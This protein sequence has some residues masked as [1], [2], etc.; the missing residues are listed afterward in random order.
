MVD[1]LRISYLFTDAPYHI[2]DTCI[3]NVLAAL[4]W[5][6]YASGYNFVTGERDLMF[7]REN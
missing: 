6:W 7:R 2:L 5:E 1:I 4:G 3:E